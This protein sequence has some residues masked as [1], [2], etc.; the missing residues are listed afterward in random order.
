[1]FNKDDIYGA[2]GSLA[3][4]AVIFL[5]LWFTVLKTVVL[6]KMEAFWLTSETLIL[7]PELSNRNIPDSSFRKRQRLLRLQLLHRRWKRPRKIC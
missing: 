1:M 3:F 6:R 2:I 4:H 5:I 7:L